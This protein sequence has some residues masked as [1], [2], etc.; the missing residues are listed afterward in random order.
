MAADQELWYSR[1]T[2]TVSPLTVTI[3]PHTILATWDIGFGG[4]IADITQPCLETMGV[5]W[6]G[7]IPGDAVQTYILPSL[8]SGPVQE[9]LYPY[10]GFDRW[11]A[12]SL[13]AVVPME[14]L[15]S[16]GFDHWRDEEFGKAARWYAETCYG[17]ET[18]S[19]E[20]FGIRWASAQWD[21]NDLDSLDRGV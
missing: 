10:L 5:A 16:M 15:D 2:E 12:Y 6:D 8:D 13:A 1:R 14:W 20:R 19:R 7:F 9:L 17:Q 4:G 21:V 18:G 11:G 3:D